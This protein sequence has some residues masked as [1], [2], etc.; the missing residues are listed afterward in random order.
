MKWE[1]SHILLRKYKVITR[2]S[3]KLSARLHPVY[4]TICHFMV[5]SLDILKVYQS[6]EICLSRLTS[7]NF[8]QFLL[9][10]LASVTGLGTDQ[11]STFAKMPF[12]TFHLLGIFDLRVRKY[13]KIPY[14]I[15]FVTEPL[16]P[17]WQPDTRPQTRKEV[18]YLGNLVVQFRLDF[19]SICKTDIN[20]SSCSQL[21]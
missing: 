5:K 21:R 3:G 6:L 11:T 13:H 20:N 18:E 12:T 7:S 4:T 14:I 10:Q 15:C 16:V 1:T 17:S 8:F 2:A 19:I 9:R